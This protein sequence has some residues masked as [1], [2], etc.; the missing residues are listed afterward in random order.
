M[1][2]LEMINEIAKNPDKRFKDD[3]G[4]T[5]FKG[6]KFVGGLP[7]KS[8]Y[9]MSEFRDYSILQIGVFDDT[10]IYEEIL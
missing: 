4:N 10:D 5:Y 7:S 1:T 9:K 2:R 3:R 6:S 8:L